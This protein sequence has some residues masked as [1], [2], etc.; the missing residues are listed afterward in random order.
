M[1][2]HFCDLSMRL[3]E[4]AFRGDLAAVNAALAAGAKPDLKG[5]GMYLTYPLLS[6]CA[7]GHAA[8]V[9]RLLAAGASTEVGTH[10][11]TAILYAHGD[12]AITKL[13][14]D[15][16]AVA[17][18]MDFRGATAL[19]WS[20]GKR[21]EATARLLRSRGASLEA[22]KWRPPSHGINPATAK[23]AALIRRMEADPAPDQAPPQI[24]APKKPLGFRPSFGARA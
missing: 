8:V 2:E 7:R 14:L 1:G 5:G 23:L 22:T 11:G 13:L 6:A 12:L 16:G 15:A 20:I 10:N 17:D 9:E 21:Q 3:G 19:W 4:A 24:T 18:A